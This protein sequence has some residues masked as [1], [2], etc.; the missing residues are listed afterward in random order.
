MGQPSF[1][2]FS[3][4]VYPGEQD[5]RRHVGSRVCLWF[6]EPLLRLVLKRFTAYPRGTPK[7]SRCVQPQ[8]AESLRSVE[9]EGA[10]AAGAAGGEIPGQREAGQTLG[11]RA[12]RSPYGCFFFGGVGG[13]LVC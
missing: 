1:G 11:R 4:A 2:W 13:V 12:K 7:P 8:P 6:A 5:H 9:T 10:A 3:S